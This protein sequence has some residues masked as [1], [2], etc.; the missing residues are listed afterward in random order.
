MP[1]NVSRRDFLRIVTGSIISLPSVATATVAT[2]PHVALAATQQETGTDDTLYTNEVQLV[3]LTL[4]EVAFVVCDV[5]IGDPSKN[6]VAGAHVRVISLANGKAVEG[7]TAADGSVMFDI[8]EL[9]LCKKGESRDDLKKYHFIGMIEITC[10]GYRDFVT[11]QFLVEGLQT[12]VIPTQR[13]QKAQRL[14]T[15][16]SRTSSPT[17]LSRPA[18]RASTA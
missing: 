3:P 11:G 14:A 8:K 10:E 9:A 2:V 5:S 18:R 13:L 17:T 12:H 6:R 7:T 1:S 15:T 16:S 4:S